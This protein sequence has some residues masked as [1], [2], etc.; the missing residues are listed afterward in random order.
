MTEIKTPDSIIRELADVRTN[1]AKSASILEE[2]ERAYLEAKRVHDREYGLAYMRAQG[3]VEDR[4]QQAA[5]DTESFA[6]ARDEAL[7]LWN[8]AKTRARS[9]ESEQT[10]LQ[11]QARLV[12]IT[13]RLAGVGER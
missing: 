3:P 13:Y 12:E 10:N 11:S 6:H 1:V 8:Y 2:R 4:K 9:L 7:V 5:V